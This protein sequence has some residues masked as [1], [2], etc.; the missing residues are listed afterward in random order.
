[1]PV[2]KSG[3]EFKPAPEG[4][5]IARC[6]ACISLG[7]QHSE[8]FADSFKI[9]LMF[10]LPKEMIETEEGAK[11]AVV[12]KEYTLSIGPKSNLGKALQSWRGRAFTADEMKGFEIANVIGAPCQVTVSH[13]PSAKGGVWADILTITGI[14]K[15]YQMPAQWHKSCRYEIEQGKD[16]AFAALPEWIR[17]KIL[18][19]EEFQPST[20]KPMTTPEPPE[21][22]APDE[23]DSVPF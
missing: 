9:L 20:I 17:K 2:A 21:A 14:P 7:T 12:S 3:G 5:H 22:P 13:K 11:P 18:A 6:F 4:T 8:K 15:G 19:C 1:M 10:E 16:E 23:E